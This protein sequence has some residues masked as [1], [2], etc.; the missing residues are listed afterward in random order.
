[1]GWK[2]DTMEFEDRLT[3]L[4]WGSRGYLYKILRSMFKGF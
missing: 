1:M 2:G 3:K 4:T